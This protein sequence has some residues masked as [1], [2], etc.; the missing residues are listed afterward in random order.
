MQ[1]KPHGHGRLRSQGRRGT[2]MKPNKIPLRQGAI[3]LFQAPPAPAIVPQVRPNPKGLEESSLQTARLGRKT[4]PRC[5]FPHRRV[6]RGPF[7]RQVPRRSSLGLIA[8][9][10]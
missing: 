5:L 4:S 10:A 2:P 8:P 6:I 7:E 1:G 3:P 9:V